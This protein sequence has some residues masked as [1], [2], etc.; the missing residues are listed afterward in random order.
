M[1]RNRYK[2]RIL[3]EGE[4][5]Y[6][7]D[8]YLSSFLRRIYTMYDVTHPS[9]LDFDIEDYLEQCTGIIDINGKD[10]YE[11]DLVERDGILYQIIWTNREMSF[12]LKEFKDIGD[13]KWFEHEDKLILKGNVVD[14]ADLYEEYKY[15][16]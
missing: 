6:Q 14:N 12:C 7:E 15:G 11:N 9:Y 4:Y 16:I 2:F 8:Q 1:N 5:F 13:A 10:L 3:I